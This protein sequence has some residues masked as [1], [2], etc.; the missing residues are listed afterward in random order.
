MIK[1][2]AALSFLLLWSHLIIAQCGKIFSFET[3]QF[4]G[5]SSSLQLNGKLIFSA[6]DAPHG[7][8][9]WCTDGTT[10]GTFMLNDIWPGTGSGI[11][12][13][14][15]YTAIVHNNLVY[16]RGNDSIHGVELWRTDGTPQGTYMVGDLVNGTAGSA[17][18][19]FASV[20]SLL[21]FT[22]NTGSSLYRSDGTSQGTFSIA[23]FQIVRGLT[24]FNGKLYFSAGVN[25]TGEELWR[26]N[27]TPGGTYLLKDLNGAVGASLP[28]NFHA[29]TNALYFMANTSSGWELWKTDG[30]N[31]GTVQVADINPGPANGVLDV[32]STVT[33]THLGDTLYF[34]AKNDSMGYQ[35]WRSDGTPTGTVR[36]SNVTNG[37]LTSNTFPIVDG[38]VMFASFYSPSYYKYDVAQ[39]SSYLSAYPFFYYFYLSDGKYLFSG[40]KLFYAGKDSIY[41]PEMWQAD[42]TGAVNGDR[43]IQETHL[44]NNWYPTSG[45]GFNTILGTIGSKLIFRQARNPYEASIPLFV[46]DTTLMQAC[47]T[48][49]VIVNV[50]ISPTTTHLVWNR[51]DQ[52][53][54]YQIRYKKSSAVSWTLDSTLRSYFAVNN[55]DTITDYLFQLRTD[56]SGTWSDWSDTIHYNTGFVNHPYLST[57]LAERP[58]DSTTVRIYWL[59]S[60]LIS[61]MQFRYR[62]YGSANWSYTTNANGLKR[63]TGLS[64]STFYE[65]SFRE[66]YNGTWSLWYFGSFYFNTPGSLSTALPDLISE[67]NNMM[68]YPNPASDVLYLKE[69]TALP[70]Q[71]NI[72]DFNGR[73]VQSGLITGNSID[74]SA[75]K[76]GGY[77]LS[78]TTPD[79]QTGTYFI[80]E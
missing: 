15:D 27:G 28:C 39:D 62:P 45:Q 11:A 72:F 61:Q 79:G 56:C 47:H 69:K 31:S 26:S 53:T 37:I 30:S 19:E 13:Y 75:L 74:I 8:E 48:P 24:G 20:D 3:D 35:L 18:G 73:L 59:K 49:S 57:M 80:K 40:S 1:K 76:V 67:S 41:G 14:F 60:P 55:L 43:R 21:F 23:G 36:L 2:L 63:I 9:L 68:V 16:F 38:N 50:P 51:V 70:L 34:A 4:G 32:F 42:G 33:M 7:R 77:V 78:V 52:S 12:D 6:Y 64:P 10:Q 66:Q 54:R 5:P 25:N 58:E 29:T 22:G 44:L 17:P 46:Y 65:Y 71:F